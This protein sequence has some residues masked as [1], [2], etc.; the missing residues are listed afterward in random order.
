MDDSNLDRF[1]NKD[2]HPQLKSNFLSNLFFCW[3]IPIF[4]KGWKKDLDEDD[5]YKPFTE[6]ESESL[7][8][9]LEAIWKLERLNKQKP[10]LWRALWKMFRK[11]ILCHVIVLF[12]LEFVLK[13]SQPILIGQ[14]VNYYDPHQTS[15]TYRQACIYAGSIVLTS[16]LFVI[17]YH[18]YLMSVQHLGMKIRI[19]CC[20]L[21]YR[22][23]LRLSKKAL[24]KTTIGQMIN[25]LS[26]DVNR[27][28]NSF[29]YFHYLWAAPIETLII[30]YLLYYMVGLT[31]LVGYLLLLLIVPVQMF[32]GKL[33]TIFRTKTAVKTD[34]RVRLMSE[35]LG[36]IQVIK[37]YTWE[38][39]F[40]LLIE[41]IRR[42]EIKQIR[43]TTYVKAFHGSINKA[44]TRISVFMCILTYAFLGNSPSAEYAYVISSF[45]NILKSAMTNDFPQAITQLAETLVS[46]KRI[47]TFLLCDE[48]HTTS[49]KYSWTKKI[50]TS[51]PLIRDSSKKS[52]GIYLHDVSAKW[53]SSVPE[54]T[55]STINFNVGPRQLVAIV[56]GV[57]SGKTSLL[58]VIMRELPITKGSRYKDVVGN[59]SYASQEPWL[60]AGTIKQ[61]ILFGEEWDSK[62]YERVIKVCALERDFATLPY[63]DRSLV[64]DRGVSLSGGQKARIN[65]ARAIYKDA[66]IYL[67]DDP[68]SAVDTHVGKQL[69]EDCI[70]GYLKNKC[71]VLVTHQIQYLKNVSKI[72]LMENGSIACT[73]TYEEIRESKVDFAKSFAHQVDQEEIADGLDDDSSEDKYFGNI[74]D[75][76]PSEIRETRNTG[77]ISSKVY[78]NYIKSGG[79]WCW[80]IMVLIMFV[81]TQFASS[82]ADYFVK[83]WVNLEQ[84]RT[85]AINDN[86]T[87]YETYPDGNIPKNYEKIIIFSSL[88]EPSEIYAEDSFF[89]RMN[90]IYIYSG[91][92]LFVVLI[93]IVRSVAF[94]RMCM[95]ASVRLHNN[96]FARICN[97]TM[98]FFN[99]NPAGRILNRFSKDIGCIDETLP[100][101]LIDTIQIACNV[102]AI[103]IVIATV[104]MWTLIPSV[105]IFVIFYMCKTFY[106]SSSRNIK[107]MEATT[108]SP[109]FSHIHASL[110]GL[111][112]IRA[113]EA[114]E[115]LKQEFDR[116]QDLHSSAFYMFLGCTRTFGFWL[117][118]LCVV[119]IAMVTLS[120]F[121]F[122]QETYGGN[123]GLAITQAISL[124]GLFGYGMRQWSEVDNSMTSVERV[125]D[126]T[127]VPQETNGDKK[128]PPKSWPENGLL[129]FQSV[130]LRYATNEPYVLNNLTFKIKPKQ[131]VGI[132]GRTGAG[133][134]SLISAL[135]RLADVEGK[136]LI[137]G[138]STA[139]IPLKALRSNIAIIPQEPVLFSGTLRSNLDPLNVYQDAELWNALEQVELKGVVNDLESK[140]SEGGSNMSVGQRQLVCLARALVRKNKILVLDE[141]TAN[142]DPKTDYLIQKTIRDEFSDCTVLTVAH[143]LHTVMDSDKVLVMDSGS[144]IEFN[145]PYILLQNVES[146]FYGLVKETGIGMF[147]HLYQIAEKSYRALHPDAVVA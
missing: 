14:L 17:V 122:K 28:D 131:K 86:K 114:Q 76:E 53:I 65:L 26:N 147:Q 92:M 117:D 105:C 23:S 47:E 132:V 3:G 77:K 123:V 73:G 97:A 134:S 124:T 144:A 101:V 84:V 79:G 108:R 125:I 111:T 46:L 61:N 35:I 71:T 18:S 67:L 90:C 41:Q 145:H 45:Y 98:L 72:Y 100:N 37:M 94:F 43:L 96:M 51:T 103:N 27:F 74:S 36:G 1:K 80:T 120:F 25:L 106:V 95:R 20:S 31:G 143:R 39:P 55:L 133:K 129:E 8:D 13:L 140:I 29:Q 11:D 135:F 136:I 93:P 68:L 48:V 32:M 57:G 137:D 33:T 70:C 50:H 64:S 78:K 66:D 21:V 24:R 19:A 109:V 110:Q 44:L 138:I 128:D 16:F 118:L 49:K 62:K 2:V 102:I 30:M 40:S 146:V 4:Y 107:R 81:L 82:L 7:G 104:N 87:L 119:Y 127:E 116:H 60:F 113:F 59:I 112:T 9:R 126:Y 34:E 63:G 88:Q 121:F 38:K 6:H 142:V 115:I 52:V 99:K 56:G 10:A 91:I 75:D 58:H 130:Y 5:L 141:A 42:L 89:S 15:I 54:N 12:I 22:K 85:E 83:F 69:F 139:D